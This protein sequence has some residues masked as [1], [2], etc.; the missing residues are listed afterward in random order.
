MMAA[1]QKRPTIPSWTLLRKSSC[2]RENR[3]CNIDNKLLRNSKVRIRDRVVRY[4]ALFWFRGYGWVSPAESV[5]VLSNPH[6]HS[7]SE[8]HSRGSRKETGKGKPH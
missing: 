8:P 1:G 2:N 5:S 4:R 3:N 6:W 7:A